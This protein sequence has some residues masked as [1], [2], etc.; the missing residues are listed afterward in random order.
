MLI[1]NSKYSLLSHGGDHD[2]D[3]DM[4]DMLMRNHLHM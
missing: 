4:D 3:N 2:G 1:T